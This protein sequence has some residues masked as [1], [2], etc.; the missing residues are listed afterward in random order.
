MPP[1]KNSYSK[2]I[3]S[4]E[5]REGYFLVL[6]NKLSTFPPQRHPFN[7]VGGGVLRRV[8]VESYPCQCRGPELPHEHYFVRWSGLKQGQRVIITKSSLGKNEF[9]LTIE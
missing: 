4:E 5:V 8:S 9:Q 2:K 7:L 1:K 3:S 6:K